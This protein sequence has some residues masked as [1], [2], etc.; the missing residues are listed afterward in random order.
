[1]KS[2]CPNGSCAIWGSIGTFSSVYLSFPFLRTCLHHLG[3]ADVLFSSLQGE[4]FV[5]S[6]LWHL[7]T[8]PLTSLA[9]FGP[10]QHIA[11]PCSRLAHLHGS[12]AHLP[13]LWDDFLCQPLGEL[14]SFG[15][16]GIL[17]TS[18][19]VIFM[20]FQTLY[21]S[22][23]GWH[24]RNIHRA[25]LLVFPLRLCSS[26][27]VRGFLGHAKDFCYFCSCYHVDLS[28]MHVCASTWCIRIFLGPICLLW[29]RF[30]AST[31]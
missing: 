25:I 8:F 20:P 24:I 28:T 21:T 12:M 4:F 10:F 15:I 22:V 9:V 23:C 7:L 1:M 2:L 19:I 31:R 13:P 17:F 26:R 5:L 16:I 11:N 27:W 3:C 14:G 6:F 29:A 18:Y 30:G